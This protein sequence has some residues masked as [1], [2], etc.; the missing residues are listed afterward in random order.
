MHSTVRNDNIFYILIRV[1]FLPFFPNIVPFEPRSEGKVGVDWV[2]RRGKCA[3]GTGRSV[4]GS[5]GAGGSV[6]CAKAGE[7]AA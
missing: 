4:C 6:A 5:C 1:M 2:R 7:P 3:A